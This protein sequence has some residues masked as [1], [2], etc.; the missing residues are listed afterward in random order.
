MNLEGLRKVV[1]PTEIRFR[2]QGVYEVSDGRTVLEDLRHQE[3]Y[4]SAPS[5]KK[6]GEYCVTERRLKLFGRWTVIESIPNTNFCKN[7]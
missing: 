3:K 2:T 6:V 5:H 7:D 4:T 1:S